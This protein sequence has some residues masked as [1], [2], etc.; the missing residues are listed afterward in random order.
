MKIADGFRI[1]ERAARIACMRGL[2]ETARKR[3]CVPLEV[4]AR[5]LTSP[6]RGPWGPARLDLQAGTPP[7][8]SACRLIRDRHLNRYAGFS[9]K[10]K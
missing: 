1:A 10:R 9:S 6:V 7:I 3:R 8:S 2:I 5:A 4:L